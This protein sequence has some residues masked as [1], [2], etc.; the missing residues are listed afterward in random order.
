MALCAFAAAEQRFPPPDFASPYQQP[1]LDMPGVTLTVG[2]VLDVRVVLAF[3]VLGAILLWKRMRWWL[4]TPWAVLLAAYAFAR[5]PLPPEWTW[6]PEA[7]RNFQHA[8]FGWLQP[9]FARKLS[10]SVG[11][12]ADVALLLVALLAATWIALVTRRRRQM[13]ALAVACLAFFGFY[14]EGCV[15]PI[16]AIQNV[17]LGIFDSSYYVPWTVIAYFA[18]PLLFALAVGRV[19]C[20]SV[21]PLGAMQDVV[22]IKAVKLPRWLDRA[23]RALPFV[24]LGLAVLLA[25]TGSLFIICAYDPFVPFFRI[26]GPFFMLTAGGVMVALSLFIGRP[27]CRFLCPYGA[28][29]GV[30]S[31]FSLTGVTITPD[32]CITCRLC[33]DACPF[34]AI[35]PANASHEEDAA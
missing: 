17:T 6:A 7:L 10:P 21:C 22:L 35:E 18:L 23:L 12:A 11:E 4:I 5:F 3:S 1:K 30:L 16:G 9:F 15:C 34:G 32:E 26:A 19:F 25:A 24:Y 33:E 2:D 14:R 20:S 27:Y 8:T 31:R 29:L 28:L 13:L